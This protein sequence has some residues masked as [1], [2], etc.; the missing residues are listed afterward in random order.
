MK[1]DSILF[2]QMPLGFRARF[3]SFQYFVATSLKAWIYGLITLL[4]CTTVAQH[5]CC[6]HIQ[7]KHEESQA[8]FLTQIIFSI[9]PKTEETLWTRRLQEKWSIKRGKS[10]SEVDTELCVLG[11]TN[12]IVI[13]NV[14]QA[15][16]YYSRAWLLPIHSESQHG[17]KCQS[18]IRYSLNDVC[19]E[20]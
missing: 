15:K 12:H 6:P 2:T 17:R 10:N 13:G 1:H 9:T 7:M 14:K 20:N 18:K 19:V 8:G 3:Q 4:I 11:W 5:P 16:D